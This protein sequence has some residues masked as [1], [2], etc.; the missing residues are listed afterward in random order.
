MNMARSAV[1]QCD[2]I[3]E[4][5]LKRACIARLEDAQLVMSRVGFCTRFWRALCCCCAGKQDD[6]DD[7]SVLPVD[8]G[9][10]LAPA[11][12]GGFAA[13]EDVPASCCK[14]CLKAFLS[15]HYAQTFVTHPGMRFGDRDKSFISVMRV[16]SA[17]GS[18]WFFLSMFALYQASIL[19]LK[20]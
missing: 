2:I 10:L 18:Q 7:A 15:A 5:A 3:S 9:T 11:D 12:G 16:M 13:S 17:L 4:S 1:Q 8:F 14:S 19:K 20:N 6:G